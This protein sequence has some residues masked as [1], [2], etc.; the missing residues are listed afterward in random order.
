[1]GGTTPVATFMENRPVKIHRLEE[2]RRRRHLDV[3]RAR[4]VEGAIAADADIGAGRA[5]Q[6]L[7]LRQDQ[8]F[9]NGRWRRREVGRKIVALGGVEDREALEERNRFRLV[10]G[11]G[12]AR[13]GMSRSMLKM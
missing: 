5:D 10:A 6:R 7:G 9:G 3:V 8:V 1:M 13:G 12:G 2:I 4:H 11:F